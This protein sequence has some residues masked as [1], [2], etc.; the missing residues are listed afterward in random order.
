MR[1]Y[2]VLWT[3]HT[4]RPRPPPSRWVCDLLPCGSISRCRFNLLFS[5]QRVVGIITLEDVLEL[6]IQEE[7]WD[8]SDITR[9]RPNVQRQVSLAK[10]K[11]K[12]MKSVD[13]ERGRGPLSP[14]CIQQPE[15]SLRLNRSLCLIVNCVMWLLSYGHLLK[16]PFNNFHF[17]GHTWGLHPQ[18]EKVEP[19]G[20]AYSKQ[21]HMKV[22]FSSSFFLKNG[23]TQVTRVLSED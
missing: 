14:S 3:T 21:Y 16:M 9:S 13:G 6:L 22:L 4:S 17:D 19:T 12:R 10:A 8:E 5:L 11:M 1:H 20:T 23:H 2:S 15:V 18:T 7:I